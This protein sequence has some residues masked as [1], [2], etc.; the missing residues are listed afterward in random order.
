[1]LRAH[2]ACTS[3]K[4]RIRQRWPLSASIRLAH[5]K[6]IDHVGSDLTLVC[7]SLSSAGRRAVCRRER[8]SDHDPV[9]PHHGGLP[10]QTMDAT[11]RF[12]EK[13]EFA[14]LGAEAINHFSDR[15]PS[16]RNFPSKA[17]LA[18]DHSR[19]PRRG[20]RGFT[21]LARRLLSAKV[22]RPRR[23]LYC[24]GILH[25]GLFGAAGFF[26]FPPKCQK[27]QTPA[28]KAASIIP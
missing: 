12:V 22:I 13:S 24:I 16:I 14:R 1:L 15:L 25:A 23:N 20:R 19:P 4:R 11:P 27:A 6:R 26:C 2:R 17:H 8:W 7:L 18:T 21:R 9:A 5:I 3:S 10:T 28:I